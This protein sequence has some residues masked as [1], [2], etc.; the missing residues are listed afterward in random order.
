MT[1]YIS[2]DPWDAAFSGECFSSTSSSRSVFLSMR[3]EKG[4]ESVH[5][6]MQNS[7]IMK[8]NNYIMAELKTT[9][10]SENGFAVDNN[11]IAGMWKKWLDQAISR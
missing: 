10:Q 2:N 4:R 6:E 1:W 11:R 5:R 8:L 3:Q 7:F 9:K